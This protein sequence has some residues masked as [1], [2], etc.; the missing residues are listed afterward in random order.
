M[1]NLLGRFE[2]VRHILVPGS[3]LD[4]PA[5]AP[6]FTDASSLGWPMAI[7]VYAD[8]LAADPSAHAAGS[9]PVFD[10]RVIVW[11]APDWTRV[12]LRVEDLPQLTV[13]RP[14]TA[15]AHTAAIHAVV[16]N[17]LTAYAPAACYFDDAWLPLLEA[18]SPPGT[19]ALWLPG[20]LALY[21]E[22]CAVCDQGY[23]RLVTPEG[24]FEDARRDVWDPAWMSD[25][26]DRYRQAVWAVWD[27][28][29]LI[30]FQP[31]PAAAIG[32]RRSRQ[33]R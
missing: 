1:L 16:D 30:R 20:Q 17:T 19:R 29:N 12:T 32:P 26:P 9:L 31:P 25:A 8:L 27:L 14:P 10:G 15:T 13:Y 3:A 5:Y 22:W 23:D 24:L 18:P 7:E 21:Q 33:R 6:L 4:L 11:T 28:T 2:C